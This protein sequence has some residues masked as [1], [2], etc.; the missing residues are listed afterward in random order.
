MAMGPFVERCTIVYRLVTKLLSLALKAMM[1]LEIHGEDRVPL[2][3]G[4]I[5][6]SNHASFLDPPVLG[7]ALR[8]RG[9][10]VRSL[11]RD[12]LFRNPLFG[13]L[14]RRLHAVPISR[15]KGDVGALKKALAIIKQGG[16]VALFPEGTRS[17]DGNLQRAKDG[18]GFLVARAGVPVVP[19]YIDGSYRA[20]PKHRRLPR[21]GKVRIY[22]GDPIPPDKI[23]DGA[24]SREAYTEAGAVVMEYI[25]I[26]RPPAI[27]E[28]E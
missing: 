13:A 20:W 27:P 5:L 11:A 19:C 17:P 6:V 12:S 16:V 8:K 28:T 2:Q 21:C 4:V 9:R 23:A 18:I 1:R 26:L 22:F 7:A 14:L 3:G 25:S 10:V 15:T 24:K